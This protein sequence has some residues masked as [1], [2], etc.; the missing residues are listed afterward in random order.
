LKAG[1]GERNALGAVVLRFHSDSPI[2]FAK[3]KRMLK[4]KGPAQD[5]RFGKSLRTISILAVR[6]GRGRSALLVRTGAG[7]ERRFFNLIAGGLAPRWQAKFALK[8]PR[9]HRCQ[10][11]RA[12]HR[13]NRTLISDSSALRESHSV[14]ESAGLLQCTGGR[15]GGE[16][17]RRGA[18]ARKF[19]SVCISSR[20]RQT[21]LAGALTL[22]ERKRLEGWRARARN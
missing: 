1:R 8:R 20:A 18:F 13:G 12:L 11:A 15:D 3:L 19:S 10:T 7:K 22:L 14:R 17:G 9:Y 2:L 16:R 6:A 21:P 4:I 5:L